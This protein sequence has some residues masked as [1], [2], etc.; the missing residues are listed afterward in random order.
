MLN[1]S[2]YSYNYIIHCPFC[3]H[4]KFKPM[5]KGTH[6]SNTFHKTIVQCSSCGLL[7]ANPIADRKSME[8]FYSNYGEHKIKI[9][10]IANEFRIHAKEMNEYFHNMNGGGG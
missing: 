8:V 9:G 7:F 1:T 4:T 2:D 10:D 5:G 6:K 3:E